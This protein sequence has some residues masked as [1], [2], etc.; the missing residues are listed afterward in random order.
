MFTIPDAIFGESFL[1]FIG[2]GI[3]ILVPPEGI[4]VHACPML[5]EVDPIS[6]VR[7]TPDVEADNPH[8]TDHRSPSVRPTR[9]NST[10]VGNATLLRPWRKVAPAGTLLVSES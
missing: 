7:S 4:N 9:V 10:R 1:S 3:Q 8:R 2:F 6:P 5:P